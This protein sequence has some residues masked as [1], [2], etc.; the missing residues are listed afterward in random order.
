M[1]APS[2]AHVPK[3]YS[4]D[5]QSLGDDPILAQRLMALGIMPGQQVHVEQ[6]IPLAG[7][8]L[9][10]Y[11]HGKIGIRHKDAAK[12]ATGGAAPR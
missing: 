10:R 5:L 7:P 3:G 9:C 2:L 8:M 12:L 6:R 4:A 11:C 1:A